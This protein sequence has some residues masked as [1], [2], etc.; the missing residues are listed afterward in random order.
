MRLMKKPAFVALALPVVCLVVSA[1]AGAADQ[2]DVVAKIGDE[3]ITLEQVDEKAMKANT[4]AYQALYDARKQAL[5]EMIERAVLRREAKARG[6]TVDQL[7]DTEITKK[8]TAVTDADV[9]KFY[10]QNSSRMRGRSLEQMQG[11]I[12]RHLLDVRT[13]AVKQNYLKQ[14]KKKS[15]VTIA[16]EPPRAPVAVASNDPRMGPADAPIT[17]VEF[18]D[19]Q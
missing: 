3:K 2:A 8:T 1:A 14:L 7:V 16:L 6:V 5:D 4:Q 15:G 18:S 9:E 17:I 12:L 10:N 13:V 11:Q 19:F